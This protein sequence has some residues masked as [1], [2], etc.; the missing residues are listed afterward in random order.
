M[1]IDT[2]S[3]IR[4]LIF[5][6]RQATE[7]EM[8]QIIAHVAQQPVS[9]FPRKINL[10]L[11]QEFDALGIQAPSGKLSS[12]QIHLFKRIYYDGQ[13]SPNTT[14]AQFEADMHQAVQH[15]EIQFWTYQWLGEHFAGFMAPSHIRNV[16][17]PEQF[18]FVAYVADYGTI[19][20]GFQASGIDTIFT[21]EFEH[22]VQHR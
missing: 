8:A 1:K 4:R 2:D 7:Q 6:Q 15:P 12:V 19:K 14:I 5:E 11:R 9:S 13:W 17:H 10:W 3:L 22:L 21:D 20:T 18:I 16:P